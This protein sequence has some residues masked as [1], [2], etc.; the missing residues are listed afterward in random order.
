MHAVVEGV[1][2]KD[3]AT[4]GAAGKT[5]KRKEEKGADE[6]SKTASQKM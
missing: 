5:T 2:G 1:R 3:V 4:K 6:E